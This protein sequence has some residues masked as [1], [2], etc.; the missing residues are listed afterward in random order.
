MRTRPD[1]AGQRADC[2][3][4]APRVQ[5]SPCGRPVWLRRDGEFLGVRM[6]AV[7]FHGLGRISTL[8]SSGERLETL[9][10]FND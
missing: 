6:H 9:Y 10:V 8:K 4:P 2:A 3:Q 5:A 1:P 7:V